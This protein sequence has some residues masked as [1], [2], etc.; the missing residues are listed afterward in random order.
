MYIY[1]YIAYN[2]KKLAYFFRKYDCSKKVN[3]LLRRYDFSFENMNVSKK[4]NYLLLKYDLSIQEHAKATP[5]WDELTLV[6][7]FRGKQFKTLV[8][9]R[10]RPNS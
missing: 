2:R 1:T 4:V 5:K 3:Y 9:P 10:G 8:S 7:C 6:E